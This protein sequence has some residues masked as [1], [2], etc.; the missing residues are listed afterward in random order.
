MRRTDSDRLKVFLAQ[1]RAAQNRARE[2]PK[3]QWL[4]DAGPQSA[5]IGTRPQ[6][7][8]QL[9]ELRQSSSVQ[10]L[11][12]AMHA[13]VPKVGEPSPKAPD[14]VRATLPS[15]PASKRKPGRP[16]RSPQQVAYEEALVV[17]VLTLTRGGVSLK[18]AENKIA[19]K[20]SGAGNIESKVRR[21]RILRNGRS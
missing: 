17:E 12:K 18:E 4:R 14:P 16:P 19:P 6:W 10:T 13:N 21:L 7:L 9:D 3:L 8:S 20:L 15:T 1:F 5:R 11:I 2:D